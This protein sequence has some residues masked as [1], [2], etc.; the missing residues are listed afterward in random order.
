MDLLNSFFKYF[1]SHKLSFAAS[2]IIGLIGLLS[3]LW[4][5][6]DF[7]INAV[8][9]SMPIDRIRS[10]NANFF[11]W[12]SRSLGSANPRILAL[13]FP[14]SAF[15]AIS[16]V[17]GL[18]VVM[19]EKILFYFV[20]TVSGLSMYY[21][22]TRLLGTKS[23]TF[24]CLA[25]LF[26]GIFYM[27]NPYVAINIL[28]VRQVSFMIYALF[29]LI[30][31]FFIKGLHDKQTFKSAIF[32]VFTLLLVTSVFV[33]P[34]F[35][36][37]T[38]FP[39]FVYLLY[40]LLINRS[41]IC[42]LL[43]LKFSLLS[44]ALWTLLNLY[45]LIPDLY[46]ASN[47]LAKV[48]NAYGSV[49][50][51]FQAIIQ[52]N[53]APIL[54]AVRLLGYWALDA[55]YK[56]DPYIVWSSVYQNPLLIIIGFLIPLIAFIPLLIKTQNKLVIFFSILAIVSLFL[57]NGSYSPIGNW[58]YMNI[59]LFAP[60][61]NTPYL[62]F[63]MY[64]TIAYAF[65]IGFSLSS[66]FS[67][68]SMY[69][70]KIRVF[71]RRIIQ[72][73]PIIVLLFLIVGVYAFPLWT[74]DVIRPDT[75]VIKSNRYQIPTYYH[76]ASNWLGTDPTHFNILTLPLSKLGYAEFKWENGGYGGPHPAEWLFPKHILT[77]TSAG[78]GLVGLA[79]QLIINNDT[80]AACNLLSL[81]NVKY[82]LFQ[83]D[84]NWEYVEGNP[85]WI[86][87]N[88]PDQLQSILNST[89][90]LSLEETFGKLGFY[91][92]NYWQPLEFYSP[93]TSI[94]FDGNLDQLMRIAER[95]EFSPSDSV[96]LLSN[97]L[98]VQQISTLPINIVYSLKTSGSFVTV[99][100]LLSSN[101]QNNTLIS[102]EKINPTK[103]AIHANSSNPFYLVFSESYDN[104]WVA[105]IDGQQIRDQ[106][107]FISN[108]FANGW[109]VNK[110]G[111][112]TII[113]EFQPQ[114]LFYL[115]ATISLITF[116]VC[117]IYIGKT[118]IKKVLI[119]IFKARAMSINI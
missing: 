106:Y 45:W 43:A 32:F 94:L 103:Y 37:L 60:L 30:L 52:L 98:T 108:G 79:S 113:L 109:Y 39:L 11:I 34:S 115:C 82:V 76:D 70:R 107:H 51:S 75:A 55:G 72:G 2:F 17:L 95:P 93:S 29:P 1:S 6:G 110:S 86:V 119:K 88:T 67:N 28:P 92:N 62:R 58:V 61:F 53:S 66:F 40:F 90:A 50:M 14:L 64:L 83:G 4:F 49:G 38:L 20:F 69:L 73:I 105:S 41:K 31:A 3:L 8:D 89:P 63:G 25:G 78:N 87:S 84:T 5:K 48:T 68:S 71:M 33:D 65:L 118:K 96:I 10:F 7:L 54:G 101:Q 81:M 80:T 44:A 85:S 99:E 102:Y 47:E 21:L 9:F 104:G 15:F 36:P 35:I 97:Q 19:T 27:L 23:Y 112:C 13:T 77:S 16:E 111:A 74:G 12:D 46:F 24:R 117:I 26:S 22:T 56:G 116:T 57:M 59:P 100:T 114:N 42:I 18:T 91:K